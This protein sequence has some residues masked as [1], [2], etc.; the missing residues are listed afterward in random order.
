M[1]N[2]DTWTF[3][4]KYC[5][6][7]WYI[8]G[9]IMLPITVILMLFVIGKSEDYVGAVGGILCVVQLVPLIGSIIPVEMAL[10]QNFDENGKRRCKYNGEKRYYG[11]NVSRGRRKRNGTK[12]II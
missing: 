10:K 5:G 6:K 1:K 4:H 7:I 2:E 8:C 3:A 11:V 12:S 9:W